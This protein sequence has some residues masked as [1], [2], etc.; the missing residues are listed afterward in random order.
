MTSLVPI[1]RA[2][3]S[4]SDKRGLIELAQA[5]ASHGVEIIST[6][7]TA[8]A[9][10]KAG[11]PVTP[12]DAVTGFPEIMD[13]RVKTLHPKV[14]GG[15][16]GVRDN[17]EHIAAMEKHGIKPIDLVCVNLYPFEATIA[18]PGVSR[19]EA[20]ENIDIGGPSM[21]RSAAKNH[22]FVTVVTDA[23]QYAEVMGELALHKGATTLGLRER[24]AGA[25]YARTSAYDGAITAYLA[26]STA[27]ES[28]ATQSGASGVP[29]SMK[30][31]LELVEALRYG[32]NPHQGAGIYRAR[33]RG[34]ERQGSL[35][36][37]RKLH[38]KEL[39]YNNINDA[40]AALELVR[41]LRQI[42]A[43]RVGACVVK[44]MNPCGA[45]LSKTP[46]DAVREA[47]AGDPLAAYGGILAINAM[48]DKP[49]ADRLCEKDIFMEVIVAP[50]FSPEAVDTLRTRWANLRML[51]TGAI[52]PAGAGELEWRSL[53]G[54]GGGWLAQSRDSRLAT[55]AEFVHAAGPPPT[56]QT[57]GTVAFLEGVCRSLLSN[58]V[59]IGGVSESGGARLFGAGAGQM[60]RLTSCRIACDK[61][62]ELARGA[63]AFSDAFF[64]FPDGPK[65]L[66]DAGVKTIV[67]PGGSKRDGETFEL[68]SANGVT[69]IT[70][71]LRHF[72]H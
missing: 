65:V 27:L 46:L 36:T 64:P 56:P 19:E 29:G 18:R 14:H 63:V 13:G 68:C 40:A 12:I 70:T 54:A 66:I 32:E 71:G 61:A 67:H 59:C 31:D 2:L 47:I 44:H 24:L 57:L 37:A 28:G 38:G 52:E 26:G 7:G 35:A 51:E 22:H 1:R 30:L 62:G 15:L 11:I 25:A 5:L 72:R 41:Q 60:D 16:L 58:A 23:A 55:P 10:A 21:I 43:T 33:G 42:D 9:I 3:I 69:C 8:A 4:V 48:L 49:S 45:A 50:S 17:P 53:P 34:G 6:G 39:S 20:I